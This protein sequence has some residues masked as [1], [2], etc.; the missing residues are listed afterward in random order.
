M[1][2]KEGAVMA[3][4][5][6]LIGGIAAVPLTRMMSGRLFGVEPVD[7]PAILIAAAVLIIVALAAAW[8]PARR[9]MA[10]D[11]M[12]ALRGE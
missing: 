4:L 2:L 6:L 8:L 5:G 7:P 10:V 12:V 9:T 1:I 11:P 3:A